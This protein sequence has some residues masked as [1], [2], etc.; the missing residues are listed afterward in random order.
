MGKKEPAKCSGC[1]KPFKAGHYI[2]GSKKCKKAFCEG[3][4][5][6]HPCDK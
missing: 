2:C 6:D 1:K 4:Y 3:C 5:K